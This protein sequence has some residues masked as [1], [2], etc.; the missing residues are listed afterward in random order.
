MASPNSEQISI[1]INAVDNASAILAKIKTGVEDF[2]KSASNN[3]SKAQKGFSTFGQSLSSVSRNMATFGAIMTASVSVPL[4]QLGK[5]MTTQVAQVEQ[6]R[7][8]L[9][10]MFKSAQTGG[11]VLKQVTDFAMVTPFTIPSVVEATKQLRAYGYSVSELLPN[12]KMLGDVSA[13]VGS[14]IGDITYLMGTLRAQGRAYMIDIRQFANRGIPIY[15]ELAKVMKVDKSAI[16]D[17][18]SE[19]KVGFAEVQQAFQNMTGEGGIYSGMMEKQSKTLNGVLSN[20]KDSF[21]K[22]SRSL[23]GLNDD[24]SII[25]GGPFDKLK[26]LVNG[27]ITSVSDIVAWL[28]SLDIS[29]KNFIVNIGLAV[30]AIGPVFLLLSGLSGVLNALISPIGVAT[31]AII[32]L[33]AAFIY[34]KNSFDKTLNDNVSEEVKNSVAKI[35]E[36]TKDAEE[37]HNKILIKANKD[38]AKQYGIQLAQLEEL[39]AKMSQLTEK[40]KYYGLDK[41]DTAEKNKLQAQI[42]TQNAQLKS[43]EDF[44]NQLI[45][46]QI[47]NE[48][49]RENL[50]IQAAANV[51]GVY[52]AENKQVLV[53]AD[54][55]WFT[56]KNN[57]KNGLDGA[58][59]IITFAGKTLVSL[60]LSIGKSVLGTIWEI[61][62]QLANGLK[63]AF[64]QLMSG[65]FNA[66]DL[67]TKFTDAL[68]AD[69]IKDAIRN[70]LVEVGG[71]ISGYWKQLGKEMD[72]SST[73]MY[74]KTAATLNTQAEQ[75]AEVAKR[76]KA[77]KAN[78]ITLYAPTNATAT[79]DKDSGKGKK[80]DWEARYLEQLKAN[81]KELGVF[82]VKINGKVISTYDD[83]KSGLE[84]IRDAM[85]DSNTANKESVKIISD[86][87]NLISK[88]LKTNLKYS[89]SLT[90]DKENIRTLMDLKTAIEKVQDTIKNLIDDQ[91]KYVDGLVEDIANSA[92]EMRDINQEYLDSIKEIRESGAKDLVDTY[93][94]AVDDL[95]TLNKDL[96]SAEQDVA[97][98]R[99]ENADDLT[100][101]NNDLSE[102]YDKL[103]KLQI[104]LVSEQKYGW[105]TSD[106][107]SSINEIQ[108]KITELQNTKTD[109]INETNLKDSLDKID[110][111]NTKIADANKNI[112]DFGNLKTTT[113]G[114]TDVADKIVEAKKQLAEVQ[115]KL[116]EEKDPEKLAALEQQK[117]V[118]MGREAELTEYQTS[119]EKNLA[120]VRAKAS[121]GENSVAYKEYQI[122]LKLKE[123]EDKKN[124]A[125]KS[126]QDMNAVREAVK[127]GAEITED[128]INA[129]IASKSSDAAIELAREIM[130]ERQNFQTKL[131]EQ[132]SLLDQYNTYRVE[133]EGQ[134]QKQLQ[135][136][137][138]QTT[139]LFILNSNKQIKKMQELEAAS[140]AAYN[141]ANK[142]MQMKSAAEIIA[143]EKK[144]ALLGGFITKANGFASGGYTGGNKYDI[145]GVVHGGEWVAPKWMVDSYRPIFGQ[146]EA[147]RNNKAFGGSSVASG[148]V[149]NNN[150]QMTNII[151]EQID[152]NGVIKELGFEL[153]RM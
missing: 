129:M 34:L 44:Y 127:E 80:I 51:G 133:L 29:T 77:L 27:M 38:K 46:Q 111:L 16:Q 86:S 2:G 107:L 15:E 6:Y 105:N 19:G 23:L 88:A 147:L 130:T 66:I 78:L 117:L 1:V 3:A 37:E 18:V 151:N 56:F 75:A 22:L 52:D 115:T 21:I 123:A 82:A 138:Q 64:D 32:G 81:L 90:V 87:E 143:T 55:F 120:D 136:Q 92:K 35:N 94:T 61:L 12:L 142:A 57:I 11:Q 126:I 153:S 58:F 72:A 31:L 5:T 4:E 83:A 128:T 96:L 73:E 99:K 137:Y 112:T 25:E 124:A 140:L 17:L 40:E 106:T 74:N 110:E 149:N 91:Q 33:A 119:L 30:A 146:L 95:K 101:T 10:T 43:N 139:N 47:K 109:L 79:P 144:G 71:E 150:V 20:L 121:L 39:Q 68:S 85:N 132:Q 114:S 108:N 97:D 152:M 103:S 59:S 7:V 89:K 62:K 148:K 84:K 134:T 48:S 50:M 13:G 135:N 54:A 14:D 8:A 93:S 125:E 26:N 60:V 53:G 116:T 63:G 42:D 69:K 102:Q 70:P 65:N 122:G 131:S 145:A 28:D 41:N 104:K 45:T 9:D 36:E 24:F 67:G 49:D 76:I 141:A 98:K 100:K 118:L 113:A